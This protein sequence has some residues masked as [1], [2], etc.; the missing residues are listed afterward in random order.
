MWN[1]QQ[2]NPSAGTNSKLGGD[3]MAAQYIDCIVIK[4]WKDKST[5]TYSSE[6]QN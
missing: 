1:D 2:H 5:V 3:Q 6:H 4:K